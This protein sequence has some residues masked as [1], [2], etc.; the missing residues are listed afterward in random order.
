MPD[1]L[2]EYILQGFSLLEALAAPGASML[3]PK[4]IFLLPAQ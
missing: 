3:S 4:S 1:M 2:V